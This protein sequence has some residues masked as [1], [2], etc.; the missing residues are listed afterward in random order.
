MTAGIDHVRELSP[1]AAGF[2]V[3]RKIAFLSADELPKT[4]T[5]KVQKY[6]R[7]GTGPPAEATPGR[8]ADGGWY[9]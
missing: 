3:P 2:K 9:F 8:P 6:L 5:G 7:Q 1:G 4:S